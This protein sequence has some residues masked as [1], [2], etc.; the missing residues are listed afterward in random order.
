M[1]RVSC[2]VNASN[3]YVTRLYGVGSTVGAAGGG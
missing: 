1:R 2:P 3:V